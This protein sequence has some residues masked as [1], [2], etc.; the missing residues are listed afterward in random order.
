ML[1]D[2]TPT[3]TSRTRK[4]RT[5]R[6]RLRLDTAKRL[7]NL[8]RHAKEHKEAAKE[9]LSG[10]IKAGNQIIVRE[11]KVKTANNVGG[12]LSAPPK[13]AAKFRKRQIHKTWLPTHIFHS[14]RAHMTAPKDPLWRFAIP[15]TPTEKSYRPTHRASHLRGAVAWDMSYMSTISLEGVQQSIV[16]LLRTMGI[17]AGDLGDKLWRETGRKW[18]LGKRSWDGWIYERNGWPTEVI[19]PVTIIWCV[20]QLSHLE[21]RTLDNILWAKRKVIIRVHPSAF[22][23]LWTEL[24][25]VAKMQHP[26]VMV[27]DLRFEIGSIEVIG[28]GSTEALL[29]VLKPF[30]GLKA[31]PKVL[32]TPGRVWT[33]L[34]GLTNPAS[35]PANAI[36]GFFVS[37]PRLRYPPSAIPHPAPPGAEERLLDVLSTWPPDQGQSPPALFERNAR[38]AAGRQ[39]PSQKA[40]NRRKACAPP[41]TYPDP[42]PTDP[43][44]PVLLIAS[45]PFSFGQ[46]TW[47]VLLPWKCVLPVWYVLMHYPLASGGTVRFGGLNE[48]RQIAFEA[49]TPWFPADYPGTKAGWEWEAKEREKRKR[50]WESRPKGKRI[51]WS[52]VDLGGGH[53]GEVGLG[54]ACDW[55]RLMHGPPVEVKETQKTKQTERK[56]GD[57]RAHENSNA[58]RAAKESLPRS[59]PSLQA[60]ELSAAIMTVKITLLTRG[61]PTACARIYRLPTTSSELRQKWL[62]LKNLSTKSKSRQKFKQHQPRI[63]D[64]STP[65]ARRR[66]LAASLIG[67]RAVETGSV[68]AGHPDYPI[69]PGEEDLIG[70]I[71]TG[72]FSLGEGIGV[73]I[74]SIL[75]TKVA[76]EKG[77]G[78]ERYLCI[79]REAGMALG[80][81]AKWEPV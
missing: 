52:S 51:E 32:D 35:L 37:D 77:R 7:Q 41:G 60:N 12:I 27:E 54:W 39:L 22:L 2:N 75:S 4:P 58:D 59:S 69:V 15:L 30:I 48:K 29:G 9:A 62:N 70:F 67:P 18:G 25:E 31:E 65:E 72:N 64:Q 79:V 76:Q 20:H 36:L 42:L 13:T 56:N 53:K 81:L 33:R 21:S 74:G 38:L 47:T 26:P 78:A 1:E 55:E 40:I 19:A 63:G 80:R 5:A 17:G 71:T 8:A 16:S 43:Q 50:D 45:R 10:G 57:S 73:G 11:P 34:A 3:V 24:L 46:G 23:Q 28:P 68:R 44:I 61:T 14:K 6:A 49:G 66:A